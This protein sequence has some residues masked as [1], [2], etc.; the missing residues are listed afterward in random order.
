MKM[1]I[2]EIN[3]DKYSYTGWGL[4]KEALQALGNIIIKENLSSALEFGSGQSTYFLNDIGMETL[5]LDDDIT[6]A[7]KANN[8]VIKDLVTMSDEMFHKVID[9]QVKY[10]DI[11]QQLEVV[12]IRSTRQRNCFYR[13][14]E[15]DI[16]KEFDLII[17]DGP[18]G[19]G[20][21]ISFNFIK[22]YMIYPFYILIDDHTH[23][24]FIEHFNKSFT[25]SKL[26]CDN[27]QPYFRIYKVFQ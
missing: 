16:D 22:P 10:I 5:S 24:P 17:L 19:N 9:D 2:P 13:L 4:Q 14:K 3:Y 8:V 21:S 26:I 23:Y 6:Y 20:R 11:C 7:A 1:T 18:N 27:S 12:K 25:K 15:S